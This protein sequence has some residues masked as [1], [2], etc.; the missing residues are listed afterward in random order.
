ML[1]RPLSASKHDLKRHISVARTV[2]V[3]YL[4][5]KLIITEVELL[6]FYNQSSHHCQNITYLPV[7]IYFVV[8]LL[9][10]YCQTII[11][12]LSRLQN[13]TYLLSKLIYTF[14][15][16]P[17][18]YKKKKQSITFLSC[19]GSTIKYLHFYCKNFYWQNFS[20]FEML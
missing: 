8:K 14:V 11:Y 19:P 13:I 3:T 2:K 9:H 4:L 16:L 12:L 7:E 1:K 10:F 5:S 17:H 6:Q 15:K 20:S 18:I